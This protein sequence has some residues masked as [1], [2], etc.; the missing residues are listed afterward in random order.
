[1]VTPEGSSPTGIGVP[2]TLFVAKSITETVP[3]PKF[4]INMFPIWG[5]GD[6]KGKSP[7]P[8]RIHDLVLRR[9]DH[10]YIVGAFIRDID[11]GRPLRWTGAEEYAQRKHGP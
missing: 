10:R 11:Q 3:L 2:T 4:V 7:H 5:D 9:V 6:R 8:D 1:M